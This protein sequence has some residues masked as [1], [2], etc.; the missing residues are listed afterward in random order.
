MTTT[1]PTHTPA[2]WT[3][4]PERSEIWDQYGV[5]LRDVPVNNGL[6]LTAA[7]AMLEALR[8]ALPYVAG[9]RPAELPY[10]PGP[11][12]AVRRATI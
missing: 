9:V 4:H 6:L 7:P 1:K 5:M 2:P 8:L 10:I 11:R 12:S 3:W